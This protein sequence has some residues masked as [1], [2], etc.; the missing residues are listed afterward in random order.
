M[1]QRRRRF[2]CEWLAA[3]LIVLGVVVGCTKAQTDTATVAPM[4]KPVGKTVAQPTETIPPT[5]AFRVELPVAATATPS[6]VVE[7][8]TSEGTPLPTDTPEPSA[9]PAPTKTPWPTRAPTSA[10]VVDPGMTYVSGGEFIF[11]SDGAKEDESPQQTMYVDGFNIDIHPVTC[12]EYKEF[13]DA[14]RHRP[15]RNWKDGQIPAGQEEHPVVWVSW[16]DALAYAEWAGKRLPTEIEWEKAARGTDGR[17]YP[18]GNTFD[19]SRCN[20][21]EANLK[22]TNPV[23]EFP[24]GASPYGALDMAGNVWEWTAD[25]Y[26]AYRGSVYQLERF[27]TTHKVFRGGSWFDGSDAVRATTRNSGKPDFMFSTIGFRC[28]K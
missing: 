12:A 5:K 10:P 19:S 1:S 20:S 11:G 24:G 17:I 6:A 13:V 25:W 9:T 28:A 15:P 23:G 26:D 14:M 18:W 21:R 16:D 7:E 4:E 22:K 2:P 27:G 3:T 8:A